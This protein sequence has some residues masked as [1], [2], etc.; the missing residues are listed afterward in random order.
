MEKPD[1]NIFVL[2]CGHG[3]GNNV[4][5]Q[6]NGNSISPNTF[7]EKPCKCILALGAESGNKRSNP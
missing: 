6:L 4:L 1:K 5:A 3:H 2:D 7:A